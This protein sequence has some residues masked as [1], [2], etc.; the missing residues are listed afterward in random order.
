MHP[1]TQRVLGANYTFG[2][3]QRKIHTGMINKM[4]DLPVLRSESITSNAAARITPDL[5]AAAKAGSSM[6]P[7]LEVLIRNAPAIS[8]VYRYHKYREAVYK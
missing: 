4:V 3:R 8:K 1:A 6:R 7:A 5:S 2:T